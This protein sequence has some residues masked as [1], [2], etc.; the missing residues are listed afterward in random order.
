[1]K[2]KKATNGKSGAFSYP[3]P[4][5]KVTKKGASESEPYYRPDGTVN[6]KR[7]Q[8]SKSKTTKKS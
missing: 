6:P 1:M 7:K 2:T 4:K 5:T 3:L 8:S